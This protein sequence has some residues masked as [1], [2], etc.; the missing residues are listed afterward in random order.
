MFLSGVHELKSL[1]R[2]LQ[3][4]VENQKQEVQLLT[5]AVAGE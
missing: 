2:E 1:V 4:H 5:T 3:Y